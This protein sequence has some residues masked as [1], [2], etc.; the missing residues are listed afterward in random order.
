MMRKAEGTEEGPS[1]QFVKEEW[2][3]ETI[4]SLDFFAI[5]NLYILWDYF[6]LEAI[7]KFR[8]EV[9][10]KWY[11]KTFGVIGQLIIHCSPSASAFDC[12]RS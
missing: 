2:L 7:P 4:E 6:G 10:S 12:L 11:L 5:A 1:A 8:G 9:V 3:S